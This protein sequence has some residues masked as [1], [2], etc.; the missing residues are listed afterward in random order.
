MRPGS[1][2]LHHRIVKHDFRC[3]PTA[4]IN[5]DFDRN[6]FQLIFG[7]LIKIKQLN[8]FRELEGH[9]YDDSKFTF[10]RF[11]SGFGF[12]FNRGQE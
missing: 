6:S 11:Q 2:D 9:F 4:W 10:Y 1:E 12:Y 8:G 7:Y 5:F 3:D